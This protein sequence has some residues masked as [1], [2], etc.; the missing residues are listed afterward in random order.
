[1]TTGITAGNGSQDGI[2]DEG[3][4]LATITA[5]YTVDSADVGKE[6]FVAINLDPLLIASGENR[7]V[8]DNAVLIPEPSSLALAVLGVVLLAFFRRRR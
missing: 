7:Y 3:D 4:S 8:V 6:V 5:S 1:M 2:G